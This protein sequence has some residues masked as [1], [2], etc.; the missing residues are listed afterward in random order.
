[1]SG[2]K[3][4]AKTLLRHTFSWEVSIKKIKKKR[5]LVK[6]EVNC[7]SFNILFLISCRRYVETF[8]LL[9]MKGKKF[10]NKFLWSLLIREEIFNW[11]QAIK[12]WST[13][14]F[15]KFSKK[16]KNF[17]QNGTFLCSNAPGQFTKL[18]ANCKNSLLGFPYS[19]FK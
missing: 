7:D 1:M 3:I 13:K 16:S 15:R 17:N 12:I 8:F 11:V 5:F 2:I 6:D 14:W 4:R 18:S 10:K 19:A 9:V